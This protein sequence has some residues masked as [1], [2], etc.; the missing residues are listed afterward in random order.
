[1]CEQG[2]NTICDVDYLDTLSAGLICCITEVGHHTVKS[3]VSNPFCKCV[4]I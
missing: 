4:F 3:M 1:M 2:R